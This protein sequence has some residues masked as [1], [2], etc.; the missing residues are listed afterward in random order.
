MASA[1]TAAA[2][3]ARLRSGMASRE[4]GLVALGMVQVLNGKRTVPM[5]MQTPCETDRTAGRIEPEH[6]RD[7]PPPANN[8]ALPRVLVVDGD[9]LLRW[10]VSET[11]TSCGCRVV[12]ACDGQSAIEAVSDRSRPIDVVL[13]D[14]RLSIADDLR[15]L[16]GIRSLSPTTPVIVMTAYGCPDTTAAAVELGAAAVIDKPFEIADL[17]SFVQSAMQ[18][19]TPPGP[20]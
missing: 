10:S 19:G 20:R 14:V 9:P 5:V 17:P 3:V 2:I 16:A 1:S 7:F 11:L 6:A 18:P 15:V 8:S 13:L 12:E 4:P